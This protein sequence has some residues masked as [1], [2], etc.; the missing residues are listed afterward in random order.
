MSKLWKV[1]VPISEHDFH[2]ELYDVVYNGGAFSWEFPVEPDEHGI[3]IGNIQITFI[4][5]DEY[6]DR[7]T[8]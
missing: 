4:D 2:H 5:E 7:E 3:S 1:E 8:K 6:H